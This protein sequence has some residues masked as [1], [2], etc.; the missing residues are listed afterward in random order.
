MRMNKVGQ[1][2]LSISLIIVLLIMGAMLFYRSAVGMAGNTVVI[3]VLCKN[4]DHE[5][6][7][8]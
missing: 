8:E 5:I 3:P 6:L 1:F 4:L 2:T 7:L